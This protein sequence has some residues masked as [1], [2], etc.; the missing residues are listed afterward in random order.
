MINGKWYHFDGSGW[1]QTGWLQLGSTWYYLE[2]SGAMAENKWVG[3]YYLT[4]S[5]AMAIDQW[6]GNKYVDGNGKWDRSK[7]KT[8]ALK[9]ISLNKNN[10]SLTEGDKSM[11]TVTYNPKNT[12][13]SKAVSWTSSNTK[14][15]TVKN[16][17]VLA[18]GAG[19]ATI[20]AM[21]N[22]KKA[23]C[24]V[25]VKK[26]EIPLQSISL[27]NTSLKLEKGQTDTLKVTYSPSNTT[28]NKD[29]TWTSSDETIATVKN[30]IVTAV[31]DGT[32]TITAAVG[33]KSASCKIKVYTPVPLDSISLSE[34]NLNWDIT[35][36]DETT[37][38]VTYDPVD[39][40]DDKKVTW[41]SSD[42]N[43][44]R[45]T[46]TGEDQE[47]ALVVAEGPGTATITAKVGNKK[48]EC[49]VNF[50]ASLNKWTL[51][52]H[53]LELDKGETK[54]LTI[55]FIPDYTTDPKD[56][57][58]SSSDESVATVDENGVV[59]A[60]S[61]GIATITAINANGTMDECKVTVSI[62]R[63]PAESLSLTS[64]SE[65]DFAIINVEQ[66]DTLL[67]TYGPENTTDRLS[68]SSSDESI[69]TVQDGVVTGISSGECVITAQIGELTAECNI[70][71]PYYFGNMDFA[72][73]VF[74]EINRVR[75]EN[76]LHAYEWYEKIGDYGAKIVAGYDI[77]TGTTSKD[78]ANHAGQI[79]VGI[80]GD[81]DAHSVVQAWL[82]SPMHRGTILDPDEDI[83]TGVVAVAQKALNPEKITIVGTSII[84]GQGGSKEYLDSLDWSY[85]DDAFLNI[86]PEVDRT[87]IQ[88]YLSIY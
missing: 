57:T 40:T 28:D 34:Q 11:L 73:E 71:V 37:L 60:I 25:T 41:S 24:A 6:I 46:G 42:E 70:C 85:D 18:K 44:V 16:G 13:V 45:V 33:K 58:W 31:S 50:T 36:Q 49:K 14:V 47:T 63:V 48:A 1:M 81:I 26:K 66:Q 78:Y 79:G 65:K 51:N 77:M 12:T 19:T 23:T 69:A 27:N 64:S 84:F 22:G 35:L 5:G 61:E 32:A 68:W 21:V 43:V 56:T 17:T 4:G 10:L 30:G 59:T 29:I 86:M 67:A 55:T 20:T 9:S 8:V 80:E 3:D 74:D 53:N 83:K 82:N 15:A 75:V 2:N 39:T 87:K 38:I 76:G 72:H 88:Q 52:E 54:Q 62:P 7:K